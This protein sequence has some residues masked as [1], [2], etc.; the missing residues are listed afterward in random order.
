MKFV[1]SPDI[2]L[3]GWLGSKHQLTIY[4][5]FY[6]R[7]PQTK[8]FSLPEMYRKS[9]F[10]SKFCKC[11]WMF[12]SI[13]LIKKKFKITVKCLGG[14]LLMAASLTSNVRCP[15]LDQLWHSVVV[16][17]PNHT[18]LHSQKSCYFMQQQAILK[19]TL[20]FIFIPLFFIYFIFIHFI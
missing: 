11:A 19:Q 16:C 17:T 18:S 13:Y 20:Y 7:I 3:S 6:C 14:L 10:F 5:P 15:F 4:K 2:F 12:W 9:W 1:F 8:K